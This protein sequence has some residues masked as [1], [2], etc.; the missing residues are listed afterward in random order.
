LSRSSAKITA[1]GVTITSN[2]DSGSASFTQY[3]LTSAQSSANAFTNAVALGSCIVFTQKVLQGQ[4]PNIPTPIELDAGPAINVKGPNGT[5]QMPKS[6]TGGGYT[7]TFGTTTTLP[8]IPGLPG[9][10]PPGI[11]G[12]PG[13]TPAFLDAGAYAADNGTGGPDVSGFV[14]NLTIPTPLV[15]ANMDAIT[16]VQVAQ[17]VTVTWTGG[18]NSTVM[19]LG[20]S[21]NTVNGAMIAGTFICTAP[22]SAGQFAVPAIVT[23]SLPVSSTQSTG[24]VSVPTG[25]LSVGSSVNAN[26][27][28]K[29]IDVG[30]ISSSV[31][32]FKNVSYQ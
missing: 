28:A 17:G 32:S 30:I 6:A 26:F 10:L 27:T 11:P 7:G 29:G 3:D 24:G 1:Q 15:W 20:N 13:A 4:I 23:S 2:T 19:I 5:K 9:G 31:T 14:A 25:A 18:G 12:L 16:S 22:A 21:S 8:S